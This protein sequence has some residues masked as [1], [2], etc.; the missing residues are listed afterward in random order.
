VLAARHALRRDLERRT[1]QK[2][3]SLVPELEL[4]FSGSPTARLAAETARL[5]N[6]EAGLGLGVYDMQGKLLTSAD[7]EG[8]AEAIRHGLEMSRA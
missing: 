4:A 5:H 1:A 2:T 7:P 3:S 6:R 8:V